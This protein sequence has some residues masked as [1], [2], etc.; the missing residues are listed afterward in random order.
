MRWDSIGRLAPAGT[1]LM[2]LNGEP[3]ISFVPRSDSLLSGRCAWIAS[4]C[5]SYWSRRLCVY[6]YLYPD[7]TGCMRRWNYATL[8]AWSTERRYRCC[9]AAFGVVSP[10]VPIRW[11]ASFSGGLTAKAVVLRW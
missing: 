9:A 7:R 6:R 10:L 11:L 8:W 4:T 3:L 5:Q 2:L 1:T